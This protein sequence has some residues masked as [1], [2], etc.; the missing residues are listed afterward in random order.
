LHAISIDRPRRSPRPSGQ[1]IALTENDVAA[2]EAFRKRGTAFFPP[3]CRRKRLAASL[4]L[5][6]HRRAASHS[7]W[8]SATIW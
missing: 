3:L 4:L 8:V 2:L 5:G 1:R 6:V 7:P